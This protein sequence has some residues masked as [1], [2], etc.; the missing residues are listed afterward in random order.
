MLGLLAHSPVFFIFVLTNFLLQL[1]SARLR[2]THLCMGRNSESRMVMLR[3]KKVKSLLLVHNEAG[4]AGRQMNTG[5]SPLEQFQGSDGRQHLIDALVSQ[6]LVGDRD[7]AAIVAQRLKLEEVPAGKNLIRQGASDTDLFLILK[8]AVSIAV[9]GR[10]VARKEAGEHVGEMAVVDP[11][12][13]RSA[14]VVATADSV[15]ARIAEPDFS[16]LAETSGSG[17]RATTESAVAT[18]DAERGVTGSTTAISPTCS[19]ASL[20]A[21]SRPSTAIETAPFRIRKRSVSD[22]PCLMRF[23]PA[24]TSSN[25]RRCAT[26]AARSLSPTSGCETNASIR[27]CRPSEP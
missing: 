17:I 2:R 15:V 16:A 12:T 25:L 20:R 5:K 6:P 8:G 14:S 18:T 10:E 22:A 26:I 9:D 23:F 1:A 19:P 7:L 13:P 3:S 21:T 11:V 27:C 24:G 4:G